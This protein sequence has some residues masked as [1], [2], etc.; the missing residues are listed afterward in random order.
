MMTEYSDNGLNGWVGDHTL[1]WK[2][3][4]WYWLQTQ[5]L[6][7]N[8]LA[9]LGHEQLVTP[10]QAGMTALHMVCWQG[11]GVLCVRQNS[12]FTHTRPS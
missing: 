9:Q 4:L 12:A 7:P 11:D 1:S 2:D 8:D 6:T 10:L 5:T 3:S